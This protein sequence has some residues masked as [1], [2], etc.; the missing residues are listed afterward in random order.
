MTVGTM[1]KANRKKISIHFKCGVKGE[2][3]LRTSKETNKQVTADQ[4]RSEL[5]LKVK[6]T[7][8]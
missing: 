4:I 6:M 2:L 3:S 5:S 1:K 7:D 8:N